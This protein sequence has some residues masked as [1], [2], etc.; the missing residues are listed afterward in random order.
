[1]VGSQGPSDPLLKGKS[2]WKCPFS[3][4][5]GPGAAQINTRVP[6]QTNSDCPAGE[7]ALGWNSTCEAP[8]IEK[9]KT[10]LPLACRNGV[11]SKDHPK[12]QLLEKKITSPMDM[13]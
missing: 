11:W 2:T 4:Y 10:K 13:D 1:M 3:P 5:G 8:Y 7:P 6:I 12:C 9:L